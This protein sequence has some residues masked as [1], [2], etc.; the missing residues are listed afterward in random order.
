MPQQDLV[1][2]TPRIAS[3]DVGPGRRP[4]NQTAVD[5]LA[6]SIAAIGLQSP[7]TVKFGGGRYT[8][9]TGAHRLAACRKLRWE[10]IPA[11]FSEMSERDARLWEISEN[12]HRA[13]LTAGERA[14]Q[15][16]EWIRLTTDGQPRQVDATVLSDGRAAG[17]QHMPSGTRAASR[18]L[19]ISEPAARRAVRIAGIAPEAREAA[20]EAGLDDN[21]SALL[22]VA[23]AAPEKQIEVLAGIVK[24][25]T[26]KPKTT[27]AD[28]AAKRAANE[29]K[30]RAVAKAAP[31]V[32]QTPEQYLEERLDKE[33]AEINAHYE[34]V[35]TMEGAAQWEM[36]LS[37][38]ASEAIAMEPL[39]RRL[40]GDWRRFEI[41]STV[42]TLAR[43]AAEAW[44]KLADELEVEA[45]I[46]P[47]PVVKIESVVEV[48]SGIT[49]APVV[50]VESVEVIAAV[51]PNKKCTVT[52]C[53]GGRLYEP[54]DDG[55]R[56]DLGPCGVC[57]PE[58]SAEA[59]EVSAPVVKAKGNMAKAV[60]FAV[61]KPAPKNKRS[62]IGEVRQATPEA[63]AAYNAKL[64]AVALA[65]AA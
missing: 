14:D 58:A 16:A 45:F 46:E 44:G 10:R 49:P 38:H 1:S 64:A 3:I 20:R 5:S 36:S 50:E 62:K 18:E 52:G 37:N 59:V 6:E 43:Q 15:I 63:I 31:E 25:K 29:A 7:I 4:L 42:A 8:L 9:I 17:P 34:S 21:Q 24:A 2:Q 23:A 39:W 51:E 53:D 32:E 41:S 12:L 48:V 55:V 11:F 27:K 61:L 54:D 22:K 40:F 35:E 65:R 33:L 26:D 57:H 30:A 60:E 56:Q 47:E 19:G 13:E 28:R